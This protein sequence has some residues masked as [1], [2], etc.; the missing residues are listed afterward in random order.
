[1]RFRD[2]RGHRLFALTF[3]IA[4]AMA[5]G[6]SPAGAHRQA[7]RWRD[8]KRLLTVRAVRCR[9]LRAKVHCRREL[10]PKRSARPSITVAL[11]L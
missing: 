1:M 3:L 7:V 5:A 4:F 2:L 9:Y 8:G 6:A 10:S 11:L